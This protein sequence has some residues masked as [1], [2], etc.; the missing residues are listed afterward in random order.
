MAVP[1]T[2][3]ITPIILTPQPLAA[4]ACAHLRATVLRQREQRLA[5]RS[6]L[7][8]SLVNVDHAAP[9]TFAGHCERHGAH[10][11][12]GPAIFIKRR[13]GP[14]NDDVRPEKRRR[15]TFNGRWERYHST[16]Q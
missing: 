2:E 5:F 14:R 3:M 15:H 12:A 6:V 7:A 9:W 4:V 16:T 8:R 1:I 11:K 10:S 13:P